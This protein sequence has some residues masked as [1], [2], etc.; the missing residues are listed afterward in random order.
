MSG[1]KKPWHAGLYRKYAPIVVARAN[2][3]PA[4]RCLTCSQPARH[5]DPWQAGHVIDGKV[6]TSITDLAAEHRSCNT[7]KGATR[8]NRMRVQGTTRQ[9]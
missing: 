6:V 9:W 1:T 5:G 2:A 4:T 3:N 8:G 7:S